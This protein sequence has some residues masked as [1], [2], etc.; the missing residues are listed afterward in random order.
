MSLQPPAVSLVGV[1]K[2]FRANRVLDGVDF[3]VEPGEVHALAGA[4]GSGKSTLMKIVYGAHRPTAGSVHVRGESVR[5][6][7]PR[8]ALRLGIA[9]VPQE[10]PLVG[11]LSVAENVSFGDLPRRH[12]VVQWSAVRRRAVQALAQVDPEGRIDPDRPVGTLDLAAKQLVSIARALAQ[13]AEILIFDEPTSSL[14]AGSAERLFAVIAALRTEGRAV[15]FISQRLDDIFAVAD[16]VSVL[17]DGVMVAEIDV[18]EATPDGI[19]EL[20]AGNA[21]AS[22]ARSA[23]PSGTPGSDARDGSRSV[24]AGKPDA[25]AECSAPVASSVLSCERLEAGRVHDLTLTVSPGEVVGLAGLPGSGPDA[26]LA[27][28]TGRIRID[29]GRISLFGADATRWSLRR[30]VRAG[31]AYVTGDRRAQGLVLTQTV[32]FN[33]AMAANG[34]RGL[35]VVSHRRQRRAAAG[36]VARL[37]IRPGSLDAPV[38]TLSGGNQQKVVLGRWLLV[39]S[40]LW[41]LDDPTRGVDVHARADI[42]RIVREQVAAGGGAVVASSDLR[43]LLE[44]CDRLL[45]FWRGSVVAELDT[46]TAT[47]HEVLALAGGAAFVN[48]AAPVPF[49]PRTDHGGT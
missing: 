8:H 15:A 10:L 2:A 1:T 13:G 11:A 6:K 44:V 40:R 23:G 16:R 32:G 17:R 22:S 46:A 41:V 3:A 24:P 5:L 43:E 4:N 42:H 35:V 30:R 31:L 45:V 28:L 36:I 12:G 33:L 25:G 48:D 20:M 49:D 39:E 47:E 18:A 37:G 19:A 29:G 21:L 26:L 34:G 27:A 38:S 14:D 7:S 9:A